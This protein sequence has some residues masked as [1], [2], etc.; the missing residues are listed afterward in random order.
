MSTISTSDEGDP[1]PETITIKSV[2]AQR[3]TTMPK[4]EQ[5]T[6]NVLR[7]EVVAYGSPSDAGE[8]GRRAVQEHADALKRL[9]DH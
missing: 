9:R 3:A 2:V 1:M 6:W 4:V 5:V 8:G 7:N